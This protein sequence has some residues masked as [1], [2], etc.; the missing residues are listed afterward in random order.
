MARTMKAAWGGLGV[1]ATVLGLKFAAW[2]V[3]GS[4]A[5]Y[6]D[7]LETTINVVGALTALIALWFSEQPADANHPYGHQKAEYISAAVEAFMVVATAFAVAREAWFGWLY[8]HA[9]ET[10]LLGVL[11]NGA[12]G[13]ANLLWAL[14]LI[15]V[16]RLWRSP[17]LAASG[18]HI[19]TDVW[20]SGGILVGFALI[21]VTGWLRL[22]PALASLVAINILWSGGQMLRESMRGLMDEAS[23]PETV[24]DIKRI[25]SENRG[26]AIE[27]HDVR[28]RV[29]GD[30]TFVEF[31]LV[32]PGGMTVDDSHA[33]CDR[34]ETA[35]VE[36]LGHASITIHVEP[37][38]QSAAAR[39]WSNDRRAAR[40][41]TTSAGV[42]ALEIFE[43]GLPPRF[44]LWSD[45]GQTL[46]ARA[47]KIE[48][49]RA[50]GAWQRFTMTNRDG[51]LESIEEIPEPHAFTAYLRVGG[52][53][54]AVDFV[55]R[56]RM[57][58]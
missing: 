3:T 40:Q 22:D 26:E 58:R 9:P 27:A 38:S 14:F 24:A 47:I 52:E 42:V 1:S 13:V 37:D 19:M 6:S 46:D 8:P 56:K 33:L 50:C 57:G 11:L 35:L 7:A 10:P 44:R 12:S 15:H 16:G 20:T 41:I 49:V 18:K 29:A 31:H 32:V 34:I 48:T 28:T 53:T 36:R 25:I 17:A 39:G 45:R 55:T 2:W 4:V 43:D 54:Y 30:M 51:Y 23:D 21:P 5:L